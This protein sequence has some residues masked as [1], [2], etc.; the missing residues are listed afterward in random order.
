MNGHIVCLGDVMTDIVARLPGALAIGSDVHAPIRFLPG[1]SAANTAVWLAAAGASV[2]LIACIGADALGAQA[3]QA[4]ALAGVGDRLQIDETMPTGSCIVLI[5]PDGER[6][7]VP[8]PGA[9]SRLDSDAF[10]PGDFTP[11]QHLHVSGY[12]LLAEPAAGE[13]PRTR[14]AALHAL[15]RARATGMTISVD[16][17]SAGPVAAVGADQ[18]REWI[19]SEVLLFANAEEA[20]VLTG[21]N[22]PVPAARMLAAQYGSAVVKVGRDGAYFCAD[23][24]EV[25]HFPAALLEVLDS[26]GAGDAFAAG[27]LAAVSAGH[28]VAAAL[29]A[30]NALAGQACRLLGG[31]PA[32]PAIPPTT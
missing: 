7:M 5:T 28:G 26:T 25:E 27:Y 8:D 29:R 10:G 16:A 30:G 23:Q 32:S 6:T 1:G 14:N 9:N 13:P 18:F 15:E 11:G 20:A 31:R 3:R 17:A 2:S 22:D 24:G 4:L 21:S 12:A 19:G